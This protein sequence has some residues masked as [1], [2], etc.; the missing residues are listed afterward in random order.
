MAQPASGI[1]NRMVLIFAIACGLA[2][3]NLYFAQPILVQI[4]HSFHTSSST[5]SLLVTCAQIGYALGLALLVPLGDLLPRRRLIPGVLAVTAAALAAAAAAPSLSVL[6]A[7]TVVFGVGSVAAQLVVPLAASLAS[8]ERR[9]QVVGTVMSGLFLGILLARTASG[10]V[11]NASNWRII[12]VIAAVLTVVLAGTLWFNI[13]EETP[14][15]KLSYP[16][17][18]RST[19]ALMRDEAVLRRRSLLGLLNFAAFSVFWTTITFHLAGAP[20]HYGAGTI[21]LFGLVGAAGALAANVAGRWA[22]RGF[23]GHMTGLFLALSTLSYAMFW[24]WSD[25]VAILIAAIIVFDIGISGL[26]ITNQAVIFRLHPDLRSRINS[27]YMTFYFVGGALGSAIGGA[28]YAA[29]KWAGV[30]ALGL[31]T[32]AAAATLAFWDWTCE[33]RSQSLRADELLQGA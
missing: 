21:G 20:F 18:L 9:G 15:P 26:Q 17:L 4:A 13:P 12:Y 22:D 32:F 19:V 30:C 6:A 31:V 8:E 29:D 24:V 5:A 14:R 23:H 2:A 27:G 3:G 10:L 1:S 7:V 28:V 11:T 25:N 33:R 16:A